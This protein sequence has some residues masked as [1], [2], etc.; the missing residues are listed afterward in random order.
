[1]ERDS[2]AML[3]AD[4]PHFRGTK[5]YLLKLTLLTSPGSFLLLHNEAVQITKTEQP[6]QVYQKQ[7]T[8]EVE[9][10]DIESPPEAP[11]KH[12]EV[13]Q[14]EFR[15]IP[16]EAAEGE[17]EH[18]DAEGKSEEKEPENK[19][20]SP[21]ESEEPQAEAED[22]LLPALISIPLKRAQMKAL[23]NKHVYSICFPHREIRAFAT[24]PTNSQLILS[25]ALLFVLFSQF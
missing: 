4:L 19:Q 14:K 16:N 20:E 9:P 25:R 3:V 17:K 22:E 13:E 12:I 7:H 18:K 6:P 24:S 15:P 10:P 8:T 11:T 2:C 21:E 5:V 23:P 1:M